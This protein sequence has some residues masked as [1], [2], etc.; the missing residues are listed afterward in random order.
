MTDQHLDKK[1]K[2]TDTLKFPSRLDLSGLSEHE[3]RTQLGQLMGQLTHLESKYLYFAV[4]YQMTPGAIGQFLRT[5]Q[6]DVKAALEQAL[7]KLRP[8]IGHVAL[9]DF[10]GLNAAPN[11]PRIIGRHVR[12]R[13]QGLGAPR[14]HSP[15]DCTVV[16]F[17]QAQIAK[18]SRKS[19]AG[20]QP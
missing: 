17:A 1:A 16:P 2:A 12:E 13:R 11:S 18:V 10:C 6:A 14:A 7:V 20:G 3:R 9:A 19:A 4:V 5:S 8:Y 15:M